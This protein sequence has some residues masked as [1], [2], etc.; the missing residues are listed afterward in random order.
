MF[1]RE[2][3]KGDVTVERHTDITVAGCP[4]F[5]QLAAR[6]FIFEAQAK[7]AKVALDRAR[8]R[9]GRVCLKYEDALLNC[10]Y[11]EI[12]A[13]ADN[14]SYNIVLRTWPQRHNTAQVDAIIRGLLVWVIL[15]ASYSD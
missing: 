7:D 13:A 9:L 11:V 12:A 1:S 3:L 4:H 6:S 15:G 5:F 2:N 8:A 10:R 14:L